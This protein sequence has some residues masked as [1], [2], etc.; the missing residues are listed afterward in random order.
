MSNQSPPGDPGGL[1]GNGITLFK[2]IFSRAEPGS[3]TSQR[4]QLLGSAPRV[5]QGMHPAA[6]TL[7]DVSDGPAQGAPDSVAAQPL[8][9]D[10]E[11]QRWTRKLAA[12][13]RCSTDAGRHQRR[14]RLIQNT[15]G[16]TLL[17][18]RCAPK[19]RL[20]VDG[21]AQKLLDLHYVDQHM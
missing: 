2:N 18:A 14:I 9:V 20:L 8:S 7:P 3:P 11:Q 17:A 19:P 13:A 15:A 21:S 16:G 1:A 12:C 10:I 6:C 5:R 4:T